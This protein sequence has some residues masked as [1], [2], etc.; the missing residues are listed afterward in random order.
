MPAYLRD[1]QVKKVSFVRRGANRRVFFLAKS[2]DA[3]DAAGVVNNHNS[4]GAIKMRPE[5]K[6]KLGEILKTERDLEKVCA[7]LK[8]DAALKATEDEITEV[9]DFMSL[10]PPPDDS[11][12]KKAQEDAKK[13]A[14]DAK[15]AADEKQALEA[16]LN[17]I[18][19]DRHRDEIKKWVDTECPHLNMTTN[20]AVEKILKAEKVDNET[21]EALKASFKATSDALRTSVA[22]REIGNDGE[23]HD[24]IA[25][26]LVAEVSK[27]ADEIRKSDRGVKRSEA[28]IDAI[29]S[30]PGQRYEAYR[31]EFNHRA[32][33]Y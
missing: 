8:G 6:A 29:K 22:M 31:R 25:G 3:D 23:S 2:D 13:A 11:A 17:K 5:I 7:L 27:S 16:R 24:P 32:R 21:A 18:E 19:E 4:G 15:K 12:L 1:L 33:T 26:N 9:R 28:V 20:D 14:D 30:I 10:M